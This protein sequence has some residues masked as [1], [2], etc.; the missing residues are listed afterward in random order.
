MRDYCLIW[1]SAGFSLR[2]RPHG[3]QAGC[4][5]RHSPNATHTCGPVLTE[6]SAQ[7]KSKP[8]GSCRRVFFF[9]KESAEGLSQISTCGSRDGNSRRGQ[10]RVC[11]QQPRRGGMRGQCG[12]NRGGR[13]PTQ[14]SRRSTRLIPKERP[15]SPTRVPPKV[16]RRPMR[17]VRRVQTEFSLHFSDGA[18]SPRSG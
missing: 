11:G 15:A 10:H 1:T 14:R 4:V 13:R 18:Y 16:R 6:R 12:R 7:I 3:R 5:S 2:S 8:A 17:P 9:L